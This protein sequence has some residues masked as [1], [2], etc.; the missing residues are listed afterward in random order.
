M[1]VVLI[2]SNYAMSSMAKAV[3]CAKVWIICLKIME[4]VIIR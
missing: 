1:H 2:R 4:K 3:K